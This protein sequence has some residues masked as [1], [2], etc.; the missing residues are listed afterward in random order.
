MRTCWSAPR[1]SRRPRRNAMADA[2]HL[3]V[4][5][6]AERGEDIDAAQARAALERARAAS[7]EADPAAAIQA[8]EWAEARLA[9]AGKTQ[10]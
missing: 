9:A 4:A 3:E 5:T 10:S 2:L 7:G 8:V 6:A 1:R